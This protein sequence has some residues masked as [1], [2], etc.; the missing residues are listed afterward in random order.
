MDSAILTRKVKVLLLKLYH[1]KYVYFLG[2][3]LKSQNGTE[4]KQQ[5]C[6]LRADVYAI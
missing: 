3:G 2:A 4:T 1:I 5:T 6:I